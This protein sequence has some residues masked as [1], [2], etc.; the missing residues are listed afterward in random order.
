MRPRIYGVAWE[1]NLNMPPDNIGPPYTPG[2]VVEL[3]RR[4]RQT[5]RETD[6]DGMFIGPCP[7][8][9]NPA[10]MESIFKAGLLEH[11]GGIESHGYSDG[12][13]TPEEIRMQCI[14]SI[15]W[16]TAPN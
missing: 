11:V 14:R 12:G 8:N 1:M 4:V 3:H 7:S 10:W 9:L 16:D 5:I 2:D 15:L 13:F 6:P